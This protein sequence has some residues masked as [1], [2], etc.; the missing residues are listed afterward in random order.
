MRRLIPLLAAVLLAALGAPAARAAP[1]PAWRLDVLSDTTAAP[2]ATHTWVVQITNVGDAPADGAT[3]P[4]ALSGVLPDGL[5]ILSGPAGWDCSGLV[6][7]AH[8]FTCLDAT[9]AIAAGG[10]RSFTVQAAVAGDA[11][12]TLTS[13][14]AVAGGAPSNPSASAVDPTRMSDVPPPFGVD[15]FDGTVTADASGAPQTHAGAHPYDATVSLDFDTVT[16]PAPLKGL[17]WPVE[18][19]KDVLADL[20]PGLVGNPTAAARC[21]AAQLATGGLLARTE[22]PSAS[23]V[24]TAIV[25][26]S[27]VGVKTVY[28]PLP[29]FDMQP[30]PDVPARFGFNVAGTVVTLD[31]ELR[32]GGDYGLSVRVRDIPQ[33]LA[34][35]GTSLT[36]WGVPA[37]HA[38]DRERAC[39][40]QQAPWEGGPSCTVDGP[41]KA[42]LRNPTS[43][44][45]PGVG[46]PVTV[47]L[48]SWAHP[49]AFVQ[50]RF[51]SHLPPGYPY[52]P[53]D[54]GAE[55]GTTDCDAVPFAPRLSVAPDS[56]R[57]GAPAG[58]AFALT[59][60]QLD[61]PAA[62][63]TGDVRRVVVRLPVGVRVNP[64]AADGLQGCSPAQ[65]ALRST[66]DP[67]CPDGSRVGSLTVE[68]PLL[69]VPLEGSI[70][71]AGPHDNPFDSLLAVYLVAKG[72][73]LIVKLAGRVETDPLS[74]QVTATFDDVPQLPFSAV[75]LRFD[76]GP[77]APLVNPPLCGAYA[78]EGELTSWSGAVALVSAGFGVDAGPDGGACFAPRARPFAPG[79]E[80]GVESP[81]AGGSSP[82]HLR[83]TRGDADE[84][85]GRVTV[86][87]PRGLLGRLSDV[88]L[89]G[90]G[91]ARFGTCPA[92]SLIGHVVA[93]AGA[94]PLPFYLSGGRVY[95]TGPYAGAPF[96][97]SVVVPAVAGPFDLGTVV[98]RAAVFV[99]RRT[100][101]LRVVTD[102]LPQALQGIPLQLRDVRVAVDRPGFMVNP[103][104]CAEKQVRGM[105][106]SVAGRVVGVHDRFRAADCGALPFHPRLRLFVGS[107][108]HTAE[109]SST[110]LT[111]V[112]TQQPGEAGIRRV[113]V[114]L[115]SIL[116]ARLPVVEDACTW[117]EFGAG[118][119][120]QA[121]IG[122]AVAVTPLLR[123]PLRGG[124]YLV[125]RLV[126]HLPDLLV[127]LRGQVSVDLVGRVAIPG[128]DH[129]A[130]SFDAVPDVPISRFVMRLWAGRRGV[131]G[132]ARNL[133]QIGGTGPLRVS[134][135][136]R[137]QAGSL[138]GALSSL[139]RRGCAERHGFDGP[140]R[141][142]RGQREREGR[143][144]SGPPVRVTRYMRSS[145]CRRVGDAAPTGPRSRGPVQQRCLY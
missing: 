136:T 89:C 74:G 144:A 40:G 45:A 30:P 141:G 63:G 121:R 133:C 142:G 97:L 140:G 94:G 80:A 90:E 48:D 35:A 32:S 38:H 123:D 84:E 77:R 86:R 58:Y 124:V 129:L 27:G 69:D 116:S 49:G 79:F 96:G 12:G 106:E 53:G 68:T 93:G 125:R 61:D 39:P 135:A 78:V 25:R 70:Y 110:P 41:L 104:S 115:P 28:G 95:V 108:G 3:T 33:G 109:R 82:F 42:F 17:L 67:T 128:G 130:A 36:F 139:V 137:S 22:C 98:V 4:I 127:A 132:L 59:L 111:A 101:A 143:V 62:I 13:R 145:S 57:A 29:I 46:L 102:P 6:P 113:S 9:D 2:G 91:E 55:Q 99:D 15:A 1:A 5:T 65:V 20:P 26:L 71:L 114:T 54:W 118:R 16:D 75:R 8:A 76:G 18:P 51:V 31:G 92:A 11:A 19:V 14:F 23:Q 43:C 126:G 138:V 120:E 105:V 122:S 81:A 131:V 56:R 103:T 34:I 119:C 44:T 73:G 37:A 7:G 24:G 60:P 21:T 64:S 107:R 66:A 100:A 112:L 88:V 85:L 134:S 87:L 47:S 10:F 83:L 117:E 72:P 52:A 50:A